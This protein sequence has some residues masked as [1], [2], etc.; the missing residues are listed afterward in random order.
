MRKARGIKSWVLAAALGVVAMALYPSPG[1]ATI[2][3]LMPPG[4]AIHLG[5][6]D[7]WKKPPLPLYGDVYDITFNL[8]PPR[9]ITDSFILRIQYNDV[10]EPG[11]YMELNGLRAYF[12]PYNDGTE[13]EDFHD[14]QLTGSVSL[15]KTTGN[16]VVVKQPAFVSPGNLDDFQFRSL[17]LDYPAVPLPPSLFLLGPGLLGAAA[18]RRRAGK[19]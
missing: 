15:L 3:N 8:A 16:H 4:T 14:A 6:T 2:V 7:D 1:S 12:T 19:H 13:R 17:S 11:A 9:Q 10:D 5:D 18:L